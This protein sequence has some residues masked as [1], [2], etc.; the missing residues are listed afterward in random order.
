M[1]HPNVARRP[2]VAVIGDGGDV[3]DANPWVDIAIP[4][5]LGHGRNALVA[6][7]DAVIAIGGGAGTL[8]EMALAWTYGR[9][10]VAM[11]CGGWSERLADTRIDDRVRHAGLTDDRVFGVD[12]AAAAIRV[13]V[14]RLPDYARVPA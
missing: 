11:R 12:D 9:L 14:E 4:T 2:L 1:T 10:I 13:V 3:A 6:R 8:S 5:G 7:S